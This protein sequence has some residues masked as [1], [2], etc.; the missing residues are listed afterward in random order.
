MQYAGIELREVNGK[1][2]FEDLDLASTHDKKGPNEALRDKFVARHEL[3]ISKSRKDP[4]WGALIPPEHAAPYREK[5]TNS[6]APIGALEC[7][8]WH[9]HDHASLFTRA[10]LYIYT[11]QPY[12]LHLEKYKTLES[13]WRSWGLFVDISIKDA[14]WY[15]GRTPLLVIAQEPIE[16][17]K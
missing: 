9:T 13:V 5:Y 8:A 4:S 17:E 16:L 11:T 10:G 1:Y 6:Y 3:K 2:Y 14:W 7:M 12:D 15:P